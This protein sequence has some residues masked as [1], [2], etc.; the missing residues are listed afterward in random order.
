MSGIPQ[1]TVLLN[2]KGNLGMI[3]NPGISLHLTQLH[4]TMIIKEDPKL[5]EQILRTGRKEN[6]YVIGESPYIS[7]DPE[8]VVQNVKGEV[9]PAWQ[10]LSEKA[11]NRLWYYD[12]WQ[13]E[14]PLGGGPGTC[15]DGLCARFYDAFTQF[16]EKYPG[17]TLHAKNAT[18]VP[19][20][21]LETLDAKFVE[22]G[23]K[24]S[25]N[26]YG[27]HPISANPYL[28]EW[29]P[30]GGHMHFGSNR[31][32]NADHPKLVRML[33][34]T[35]GV[36]GVALL[37]PFEHESRRKLYG[38]AGEYRSPKHGLEYRVLGPAWTGHPK[39]IHL[40]V[41]FARTAINFA[42]MNGHLAWEFDSDKVRAIINNNNVDAARRFFSANGRTLRWIFYSEYMKWYPQVKS[43]KTAENVVELAKTG[44]KDFGIE[45]PTDVWKNWKI[46]KDPNNDYYDSSF[47][48]MGPWLSAQ[49]VKAK[50]V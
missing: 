1:S 3:Y 43:L 28:E 50:G 35:V 15:I 17:H 16:Q 27:E 20:E 42:L 7:S 12:G 21:Q 26:A 22:F 34:A 48:R 40:F 13:A 14:T 47:W 25:L 6:S 19:K 2:G 8:Y 36:L 41:G 23:C 46:P 45:N 18:F 37:G 4:P 39:L 49:D 29:R 10:I 24:P 30:V 38:R 9:V 31:I 11:V 32:I 33:D 44:L 5:L